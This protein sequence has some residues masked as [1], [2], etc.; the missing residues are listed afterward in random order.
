MRSSKQAITRLRESSK[1]NLRILS[2]VF[3]SKD[4]LFFVP[5]GLVSP[6]ATP[7][8]PHAAYHKELR[9]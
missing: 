8:G 1:K 2:V 7:T 5:I 9:Q 3:L 6:N 4:A